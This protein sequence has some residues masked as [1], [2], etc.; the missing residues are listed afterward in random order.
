MYIRR[1][2]KSFGLIVHTLKFEYFKRGINVTIFVVSKNLKFSGN[3]MSYDDIFYKN[4]SFHLIFCLIKKS[5]LEVL[6]LDMYNTLT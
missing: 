3:F 2:F 4:N 1:L 5:I 6:R